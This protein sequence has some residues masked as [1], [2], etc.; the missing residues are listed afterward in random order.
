M[1]GLRIFKPRIAKNNQKKYNHPF[2]FFSGENMSVPSTGTLDCLRQIMELPIGDLPII[3]ADPKEHC[4]LKEIAPETMQLILSKLSMRDLIVAGLTCRR[5]YR[6]S[7]D[8]PF[9][10]AILLRTF[11]SIFDSLP[12]KEELWL[13]GLYRQQMTTI[14]ENLKKP[15]VVIQGFDFSYIF[16]PEGP[17]L[18]VPEKRERIFEQKRVYIPRPQ[19]LRQVIP[20]NR[21][22]LLCTRPYGYLIA[23]IHSPEISILTFSRTNFE[24][25]LGSLRLL[26]SESQD[27]KLNVV[28][29]DLEKYEEIPEFSLPFNKQ[30]CHLV[31]HN[32]H[33]LA[34]SIK[35]SDREYDSDLRTE[36]IYIWD[37]QTKEEICQIPIQLRK[38]EALVYLEFNSNGQSLSCILKQES[39]S[40]FPFPTLQPSPTIRSEPSL[41]D[42]DDNEWRNNDATYFRIE[43]DLASGKEI[44]DN[45]RKIEQ[46]L[47]NEYESSGSI[48]KTLSFQ[49]KLGELSIRDQDGK[50]VFHYRWPN[51][52]VERDTRL[53][54]KA[55]FSEGKFFLIATKSLSTPQMNTRE[56]LVAAGPLYTLD[57][58]VPLEQ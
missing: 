5:L 19:E 58:S 10:K 23:D 25:H 49:N 32:E 26:I 43:Y 8:N 17:S 28:R 9:W 55:F 16:L 37:L 4:G 42:F 6:L 11:P 29:L 54:G 33:F 52:P 39:T 44:T 24:R 13:K 34:V 3:P 36:T 45:K 50:E 15:R 7:S 14:T 1:S 47:R 48:T 35:P 18:S 27:A 56:A 40:N 53:L 2:Y 30:D 41:V 12:T 51:D 22:H 20:L 38:N 57:F 46:P 21:N 31:C